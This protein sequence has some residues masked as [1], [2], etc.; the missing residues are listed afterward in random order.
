LLATLTFLGAHFA[1]VK[2]D[3]T[4]QGKMDQEDFLMSA[5]AIFS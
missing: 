2:D 5:F 1:R 4:R 3:V